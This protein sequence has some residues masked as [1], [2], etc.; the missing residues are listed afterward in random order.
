MVSYRLPLLSASVFRCGTFF[1]VVW[2]DVY[3]VCCVDV[4]FAAVPVR[5]LLSLSL[6]CLMLLFCGVP[7]VCCCC[8]Y[9]CIGFVVRRVSCL[10]IVVATVTVVLGCCY[11]CSCC[12]YYLL[13]V[14]VPL[15]L[16]LLFAVLLF[17][18]TQ[19]TVAGRCCGCCC[20][21]VD[22]FFGVQPLF[23]CRMR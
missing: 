10:F 8:C 3:V 21:V 16:L 19:L 6:F 23:V 4:L 5:L 20:R 15:L 1:A 14:A 17:C 18:L 7:C 9:C 12:S 22:A 11:S 13:L 2:C